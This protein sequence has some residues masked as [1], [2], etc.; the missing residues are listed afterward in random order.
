MP[1]GQRISLWP[2]A[3][4]AEGMETPLFFQPIEPPSTILEYG[5]KIRIALL[6]LIGIM[7]GQNKPEEK[8]HET[9]DRLNG[10]RSK[11]R[12]P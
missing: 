8:V 2:D 6:V 11:I 12:G 4:A 9:S 1:T 3:R 5:S 10:N 7:P